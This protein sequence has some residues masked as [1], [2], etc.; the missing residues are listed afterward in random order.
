M[1]YQVQWERRA[2]KQARKLPKEDRERIGESVGRL[3]DWPDCQ[4]TRDIKPLKGHEHEYRLRVVSVEQVRK[5]DER[6][7]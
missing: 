6:T 4:G 1:N 3:A 2:V 7:Y 5:R